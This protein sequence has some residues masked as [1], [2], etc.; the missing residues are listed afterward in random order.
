MK[1]VY[2]LLLIPVAAWLAYSWNC[3][4]NYGDEC[5][6]SLKLGPTPAGVN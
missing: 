1:P 3:R 2:I 4:N 6:F 5:L